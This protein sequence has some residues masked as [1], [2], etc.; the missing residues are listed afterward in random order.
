[1]VRNDNRLRK[2]SQDET[3]EEISSVVNNYRELYNSVDDS[4]AEKIDKVF[5]R[6]SLKEQLKK[7]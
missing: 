2:V 4:S 6:F 5:D 7:E 1:M 3:R